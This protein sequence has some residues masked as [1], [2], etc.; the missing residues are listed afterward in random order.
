MI[1]QDSFLI[2]TPHGRPIVA[3]VTYD[4]NGENLPIVVFCH[5]YKGFKDWG[6]W[7]VIAKEFAKVGFFFLKF[8]FSHNGGTV[9]DVIDFPDLEAFGRNTYS[10]EIDDI[11]TVLDFIQSEH[12]FEAQTNCSQI[13]LIG[14]SRGGGMAIIRTSIDSRIIKLIT[15]AAVSDIEARFPAGDELVKWKKDTNLFLI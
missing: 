10:L 13:S 11:G 1:K 5:G 12:K 3:D 6:P 7:N 8:N 15:W 14:H 4:E 9:D 2:P